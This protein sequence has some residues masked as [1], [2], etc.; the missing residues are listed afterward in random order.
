MIDNIGKELLV[1][2]LQQN[3]QVWVEGIV[4]QIPSDD[5]KLRAVIATFERII[6]TAFDE[7]LAPGALSIDVLNQII[8]HINDIANKNN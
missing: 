3:F 7:K 1:I 2:K 8:Y 6:I 5:S 4:A